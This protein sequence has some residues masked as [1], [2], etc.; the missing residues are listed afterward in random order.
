MLVKNPDDVS[1]LVKTI[2]ENSQK[3]IDAASTK[4]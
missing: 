2:E 3:V 1:K 4:A